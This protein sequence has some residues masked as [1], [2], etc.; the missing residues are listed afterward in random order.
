[1][2][3][4]AHGDAPSSQRSPWHGVCAG[5]FGFDNEAGTDQILTGLGQSRFSFVV[6]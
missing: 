4:W 3:S 5:A 2:T 1:M 6:F